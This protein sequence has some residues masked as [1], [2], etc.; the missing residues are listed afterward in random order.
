MS[1]NDGSKKDG[2]TVPTAELLK[3]SLG[4]QL[5]GVVDGARDLLTQF[6]L[7]PYR[8]K[9]I[10]TRFAGGRRGVGPEEVIHELELL[11]TP[12][13]VDMSAL[14][15]VDTPIGIN[16]QGVIQLQ[17]ISGRYTEETLIG[18]GPDGKQVAPN[19]TVYYEI[20][21]FRRDGRPSE[22]RRFIRD[23]VPTYNATAFEWMVTLVNVVEKRNR[24]G[25][26]QG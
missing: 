22:K 12:K 6:G 18:V 2:F 10:R 13:V 25:S 14:T 24:D 5:I 7:R 16:E 17:K 11:P 8:V 15:E 4:Q 1:C 20:E 26:P 19:E 9:I 3:G 23:S 21:F